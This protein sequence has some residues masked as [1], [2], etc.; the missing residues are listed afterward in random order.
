MSKAA[1]TTGWSFS[2]S[3]RSKSH[4]L[5]RLTRPGTISGG[6]ATGDFD[7]NALYRAIDERRRAGGLTW[8]AVARDI[9]GAAPGPHPIAVSTITGLRTKAVAEGDGVWWPGLRG[10]LTADA[11]DEGQSRQTSDGSGFSSDRMALRSGSVIGHFGSISMPN[12]MRGQ[13][14]RTWP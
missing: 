14:C 10:S 7:L 1:L 4:R 5:G 8:A 11:R 6:M 9:N 3:V 2:N 12:P 13:T